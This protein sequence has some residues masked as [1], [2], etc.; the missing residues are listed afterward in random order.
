VLTLISHPFTICKMTLNCA[1]PQGMLL[2]P[3]LPGPWAQ[4][5]Q[6]GRVDPPGQ[7][8][9][10][11][12]LSPGL[13]MSLCLRGQWAY[14]SF[15]TRPPSRELWRLPGH[16]PCLLLVQ[17]LLSKYN[18]SSSSRLPQGLQVAAVDQQ[19][20]LSSSRRHLLHLPRH[21]QQK[22]V[23]PCRLSPSS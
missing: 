16:A 11:L 3:L 10:H 23:Y 22:V 19:V 18:N 7:L 20:H 4:V 15:G 12:L 5:P 9:A 2:P 8:Q 13:P 1:C 17:Q 14:P 21:Q 6:L